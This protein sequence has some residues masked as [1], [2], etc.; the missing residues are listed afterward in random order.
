MGGG[1]R[2]SKNV[3][4]L[5]CQL[6]SIG[7]SWESHDRIERKTDINSD[8]TLKYLVGEGGNGQMV[9]TLEGTNNSGYCGGGGGGLMSARE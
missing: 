4:W 6:A 5:G 7:K 9:K 1:G 2:K 3:R 8:G